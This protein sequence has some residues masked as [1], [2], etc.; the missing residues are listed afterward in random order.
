MTLHEPV[1]LL[2]DFLLGAFASRLA[3]R[4]HQSGPA[5]SRV[6]RWWGRALGLSAGAALVGG[7]YHGFA[8]N[9]PPA[10]AAAWWGATLLLINLLS[11]ALAIGLLHEL[12][13]AERQRPWRVVIGGKLA[14]FAGVALIHPVY[15]VVIIDYGL[16]L[17]AWAAAAGL[18]RR[19]WRSWMLAAIALAVAA[20]VIQQMRW[21]I[22][23]CFNHNDV[24][25]VIQALA[26]YGFYR[27]G[28]KFSD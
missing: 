25:H 20:A 15:R 24:Y 27:A 8:L 21:G 4:L 16:A 6:A 22:S 12:V 10:V 23:S 11:A 18:L 14:V 26:F 9:C 1:T 7:S 2:T 5:A 28:L 17:L 3:W 19:A 13:P